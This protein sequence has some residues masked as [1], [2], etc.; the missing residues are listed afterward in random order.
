MLAMHF[1]GAPAICDMIQSN[2]EHFD[3][4]TINPC[5]ACGIAIDMGNGFGSKNEGKIRLGRV[6]SKPGFRA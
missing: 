6:M 3:P 2:L 5:D 4:G 1:F